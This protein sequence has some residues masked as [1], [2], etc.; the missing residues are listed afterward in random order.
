MSSES[1]FL[2]K[3]IINHKAVHD[4]GFVIIG[5]VTAALLYFEVKSIGVNSESALLIAQNQTKIV[6]L[7]VQKR[8]EELSTSVIERLA[9]AVELLSSDNPSIRL[10]GMYSLE[11]LADDLPSESVPIARIVTT[12]LTN[13]PN[14]TKQDEVQRG[15]T[16]LL[17]IVKKIGP[18]PFLSQEKNLN[19]KGLKLANMHIKDYSFKGFSMVG[20]YFHNVGF[21]G[22]DFT[23]VNLGGVTF[24]DCYKDGILNFTSANLSN[25]VIITSNFSEAI[26]VNSKL[27]GST[28]KDGVFDNTDFSGANMEGLTY[29]DTQSH[30]SI[31]PPEKKHI[32]KQ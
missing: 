5:F 22:V 18:E 3:L 6:E 23:E 4:L 24:S 14:G 10:A 28:I 26:F 13:P 19:L 31:D 21:S 15:F 27:T 17:R 11:R 20:A 25:S 1:S 16:A 32:Y 2:N 29:S 9:K 7:S 30:G 8:A 12:F